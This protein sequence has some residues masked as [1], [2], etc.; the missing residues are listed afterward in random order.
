MFSVLLSLQKVWRNIEKE[1]VVLARVKEAH[2]RQNEKERKKNRKRRKINCVQQF[3]FHSGVVGFVPSSVRSIK[4]SEESCLSGKTCE[5]GRR[6]SA[7][8]RERGGER[9]QGRGG[10]LGSM[11]SELENS[12]HG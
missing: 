3:L 11:T 2:R 6:E 9:R 5:D 10:K 4:R 1:T 12:L 7:R 8:D